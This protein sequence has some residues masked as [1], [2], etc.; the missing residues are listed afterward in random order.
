MLAARRAPIPILTALLALALAT[1]QAGCLGATDAD[2]ATTNGGSAFTVEDGDRFVVSATP[3]RIV[4]YKRVAGVDFP[5]DDASLQ[6]KALLIHPVAR[7]AE[8]GVYARALDVHDGGDRWVVDAEPL[9]LEQMQ[10]I[11]EDDVVRIYVDRERMNAGLGG[12]ELAPANLHPLALDGL[13]FDG[14]DVSSGYSLST[15]TFVHPGVTFSHQID[16]FDLAPEALVDWSREDGLELGFRGSLAW[17]SKLVLSGTAS[18]ELFR[19]KTIETPSYV[20]L[21]PIGVVPVPVSFRAS[22]SLSCSASLT[23]PIELTVDLEAA[24]KI[25]GSIVV[26]PDAGTSPDEWVRPGRW[27]PE[28]SGSASAT[29]SVEGTLAGSISCSVPRVELRADVAGVAGPYIAVTPTY[30][31]DDAGGHVEG[32]VAAGV[33]AG[34]LGIGAGVEVNLYTWKP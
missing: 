21:V 2:V 27:A 24:A 23:G 1:G 17:K 11:A 22:A 30:T 25:A 13:A 3:E 34:M 6:G 5:F 14:F 8:G 15:P 33:G 18:G 4:L 31:I 12:G 19:S 10:S 26:D 7:R 32:H 16:T 9:T 28:A 29:P 20:A